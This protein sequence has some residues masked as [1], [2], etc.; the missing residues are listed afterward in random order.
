MTPSPSFELDR[1]NRVA[2]MAILSTPNVGNRRAIELVEAFGGPEK[3]LSAS[4]REI[5]HALNIQ[6]SA[7]REVAKAITS[8]REAERTMAKAEGMGAEFITCWD[9]EYPP[10]LKSLPDAPA[11]LYRLGV[12]SPLYNFSV[13]IVGTRDASEYAQRVTRMIAQELAA[14]GVTIVSGMA[15]GID[16]CAHEGALAAG[17]RTMAVLGC[18]VDVIY[19]PNNRKLYEKIIA[20]GAI[21]S[22]YPPGSKA[23]QFHFPQRNRI[24]SGL[25]LGVIVTE[26]GIKSG[27]LITAR[28]ALEQG[29]EL[30][31]TPGPV[32]QP[33]S[34]GVNRLLKDNLAKMI[35]CAQD[36][37]ESLRSQLSPVLN[38]RAALSLPEMSAEERKVYNLLETGSRL[39]DELIRESGLS[40]LEFSRVMTAMQ[41][42]GLVRRLPGARMARA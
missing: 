13:A 31:A 27:A 9:D 26:A 20:Q 19:P 6:E 32:G 35:D 17:G 8:L 12:H 42:K 36:V 11:A 5:A 16:T 33:R 22:E 10:R 34:A 14:A 15:I 4:V 41:L 25:S 21:I 2:L 28:H 18:G 37:V 1:T 39:F 3:V 30:F 38:V 24:I 29:R 23:D 7:A 40:A